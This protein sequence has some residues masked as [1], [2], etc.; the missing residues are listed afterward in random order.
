MALPVTSGLKSCWEW[1]C[2]T[3]R[4]ITRPREFSPSST[5]SMKAVLLLKQR[6]VT[7][8][9]GNLILD[10]LYGAEVHLM[11]T[12]SYDEIYAEM[13]CRGAELERQGRKSCLI[14]LGGSTPLG[15]VGYVNCVR[16][17]TVQAMWA[18]RRRPSSNG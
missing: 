18:H 4:E 1:S 5:I 6:G 15:A 7:E 8:R 11:D 9:R 3:D 2:A 13:R 17:F 16:E 12:D 10:E 14:P